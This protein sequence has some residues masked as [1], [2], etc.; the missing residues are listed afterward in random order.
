MLFPKKVLFD[1]ELLVGN[2]LLYIMILC[3]RDDY[4]YCDLTN[5]DLMK[6]CNVS[7]RT[8]QKRLKILREKSYI[9]IEYGLEK[10]KDSE[11][12]RKILIKLP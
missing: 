8:I 10:N 5:E 4:F 2:I 3:S 6:L 9:E 7:E 11:E 1:K 12:I